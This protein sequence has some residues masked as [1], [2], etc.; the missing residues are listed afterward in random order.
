V[1]FGYTG[2]SFGY[3]GSASDPDVFGTVYSSDHDLIGNDSGLTVLSS[4]H[5]IFN[6][7]FVGLDTQLL[8]YGEPPVGAPGSQEPMLYMSLFAGSPAIDAGDGSSTILSQLESA[9]GVSSAAALTDERG[10]SRIVGSAIDIG[11]VEYQYDLSVSISAPSTAD[12]GQ[13]I[14]Y[15]ISVTNNGPD[16]S[17]IGAQFS[18]P[19][20]GGTVF[21]SA[22][23]GDTT[24]TPSGGVVTASGSLT[25]TVQ[26]TKPTGTV[27]ETVSVPTGTWETNPNNNSATVSTA[28]AG[29]PTTLS[30]SAPT[31]TYGNNA[32]VTVN[33]TSPGGT[34]EGNVNLT[35]T[36]TN[37]GEFTYTQALGSN[38]AAT[39]MFPG[40][41]AGSYSLS[42]SYAAQDGFGASSGT[43]SLTVSPATPILSVS[44]GGTYNGEGI[45]FQASA[46]ATGV[47]GGTGPVGNFTSFVYYV[48]T[49]TSGT[50]LGSTG[51]INAGTYTVVATWTSLTNDYSS[52]TAQDTFTINPE[53]AVIGG[54]PVYNGTTTVAG[55]SLT[56]SNRAYVGGYP[57]DV[58]LSGTATL[59]GANVGP[60]QITSFAGLSL[61]GTAASNYTL[62]GVTGSV[63]V[64]PASLVIS[65]LGADKNYD[66]TTNSTA[67]PTYSGQQGT[68]TVTGLTESYGGVNV[69]PQTLSVNPGYVVNDGNNGNNYRVTLQTAG[70]TINPAQA[71]FS[72]QGASVTYDG[73]AHAA[74]GTAT[75]VESP[76]PANL[77]S[78]LHWDYSPDGGQSYYTSPTNAGDYEVYYYFYG[79]NWYG[80]LVGN[81]NYLGVLPYADS[82][83]AVD[84]TQATP[85]VTV[86]DAGGTY[87]GQPFAA[88]ATVAGVVAGVDNTPAPSL[89]GVSPTLTY[90][91]GTYTLATLP[92]SGGST[93]APVDVGNYTVVASFAGSTDYSAASGIATFS[94]GQATPTVHVSDAGGTYNGQPFP[95]TAT[96]SGVDGTPTLT[97][98]AGGSVSGTAL[99]GAPVNAGTYTVLASLAGSTDYSAASASTTFTISQAQALISIQGASVTYDGTAHAATGTATGVESPTPANLNSLLSLYYSS[100]GGQTYSG[101]APV[102]AGDYEVYYTFAGNNN[103]QAVTGYTDSHQAVDIAKA[104]LTI[105]AVSVSKTYDGTTNANATPKFSGQQGTDTVTGLTE[106]YASANAGPETLSV[107]SGYV[108]NDGNNGNNYTVTL[109]TASGTIYQ[110]QALISIQGASVTYDGTAHAA[111]GT[112]TGVES[113]TP[114]NLNSLLSLYYSSDGGQTY[115]SSAPVNAGDYEIYYTFAGNNN[116]QAVS[117]YTD[118]GQAVDVTQEATTTTLTSSSNAAIPGQPVTLTATVSPTI[119]GAGNPTG[120]VVFFDTTTQTTLNTVTLSSGVATLTISTL[121][122]GSHT[123]T[124]TYSGDN[125]FLTSQGSL[126]QS[127]ATS[128]YVLN[129]NASGSLNVSGNA[130]LDVGGA[131]I[132][133]STSKTALT[134]SGNSQVTAAAIDVAGGIQDS[135]N[136]QL[137]PG[138]T[139][140]AASAPDPLAGLAVPNPLGLS[141]QGAVNL[142]GKATLTIQPGIY[143]KISVS[144]NAS[145]VLLPGIYVIA[146]GGLTVSGNANVQGTGVLIYNAGSNYL[147]SGNSFGAI[148][149]SGNATLNLTAA[150]GGPYAGVVI[151]QSRDNTQAMTVSGNAVAT[152]NGTVYIPSAMLTVT[153][154]SQLKNASLVVNE[155][156]LTGNEVTT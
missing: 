104:P 42:A 57:A 114:A 99:A 137:N 39:F 125:N 60:E 33:L 98:Y 8:S 66:G 86:T 77:T 25:L 16:P 89:E 76:N 94:I 65:A 41:D 112:A 101:S 142:S 32:V 126:T 90:Y 146:G 22:I 64:T 147:G 136:A 13:N 9:E 4:S 40:W 78:F 53:V 31:V 96:V 2:G 18:V 100:D 58:E 79:V 36:S 144:G 38:G 49:G 121:A 102:N 143:T 85:T 105:S 117:S 152:L 11:A 70:G 75:G 92:N 71:L 12:Y 131:V 88:T 93:T 123:I 148:T 115:S 44:D 37:Y 156:Q 73:K 150:S 69:G 120:S 28:V 47:P 61:V 110:A 124:A 107:N 46:T 43:G 128:V 122:L 48:G 87:N 130:K 80:D 141:F 14:T 24:L 3:P 135:G 68:D 63:N 45:P 72:F 145:L 83:V 151:F 134:A 20:P 84:I 54:S 111:T 81:N 133:D 91:A 21:Q 50:R 19:I 56:V 59:A 155:L 34:P 132:V 103:Y 129:G 1:L 108:I 5:D 17:P 74:T 109:Q 153:G 118:S 62:T 154:N 51:P 23:E 106:S 140:N 116:Y 7:G 52:G 55:S 15:N 119:S 97:Y 35:V 95:A 10:F 29:G 82:G 149:V 113:P 6:P 26:V 27:T 139:T 138:G 30:I 127:V 67:T